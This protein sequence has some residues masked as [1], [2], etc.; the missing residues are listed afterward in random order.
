MPRYTVA[1]SF[2]HD[3]KLY[4]TTEPAGLDLENTSIDALVKALPAKATEAYNLPPGTAEALELL[5]TIPPVPAGPTGTTGTT[6]PTGTTGTTGTT[7]AS[8][9]T[10]MF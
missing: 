1:L 2:D 6:G 10:G 3:T 8:G 4:K 9:P 7:G 5:I